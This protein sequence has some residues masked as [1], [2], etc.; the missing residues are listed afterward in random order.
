VLR[1]SAASHDLLFGK[2]IEHLSL[3]ITQHI[4]HFHQYIFAIGSSILEIPYPKSHNRFLSKFSGLRTRIYQARQMI[5]IEALFS[6][7]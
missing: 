4:Q 6:A 3:N 7:P 1:Q 2:G 5:S